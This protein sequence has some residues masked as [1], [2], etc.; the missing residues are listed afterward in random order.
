MPSTSSGVANFC[1]GIISLLLF[2]SSTGFF[3]AAAFFGGATFFGGTFDFF[4]GGAFFIGSG[5]FSGTGFSFGFFAVAAGSTFLPF[6]VTANF[7][8]YFSS[9]FVG[10]FASAFFTILNKIIQLN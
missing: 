6:A 10:F 1:P 3:G 2:S 5:F 9:T 7:L 8:G 4:A